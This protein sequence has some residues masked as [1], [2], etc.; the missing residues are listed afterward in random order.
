M[1]LEDDD[2]DGV[3]IYEDDEE[4]R[5]V[6]LQWRKIRIESNEQRKQYSGMCYNYHSLIRVIWLI[7]P[8]SCVYKL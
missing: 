2:D 5:E 1:S 4:G 7:S 8:H 6:I 3:S